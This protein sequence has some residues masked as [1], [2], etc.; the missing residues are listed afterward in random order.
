MRSTPVTIRRKEEALARGG[1]NFSDALEAPC[2]S[3]ETSPCC[4]YLPLKTMTVET[5][6]DV[7]HCRYLLNFEGI[8]LGLAASGEWS[9]Y[10]RQPCRNLDPETMGC[11]VHG[12][13]DQPHICQN[14]SPYGC[15]YKGALSDEGRPDFLRINAARLE[16]LLPGIVFDE[17]RRVTAVPA[18]EWLQQNLLDIPL[19]DA[20]GIPEPDPVLDVWRRAAAAGEAP[21]A[22]T[23]FR[24]AAAPY[25]P[26]TDCSA[27]CCTTLTFTVAPAMTR[28]SLDHLRFS[29]GFPGMEL[30]IADDGW[31]LAVRTRCRN[32]VDGRCGVYGKPERPLACSYYDA[33]RCTYRTAYG[34]PRPP[35]F[36]RVTL[37]ELDWVLECVAM[38]DQG[39]VVQVPTA[40]QLRWHVERRWRE[41]ATGVDPEPIPDIG[42]LLSNGAI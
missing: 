15:W 39:A 19:D 27:A 37:A 7:D 21:A 17:E 11:R 9:V 10:Y 31:V 30:A 36:L 40:E 24:A 26:C 22:T 38:D 34:T 3:C 20:P 28:A 2:M 32:L 33:Y 18:W 13:D 8:E 42:A 1:L 29:L 6:L 12:T 41:Q 35:G 25:D 4:S 5:L 23:I 16:A 14:Y